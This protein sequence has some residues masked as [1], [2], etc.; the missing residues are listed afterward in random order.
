MWNQSPIVA[1]LVW[2]SAFILNDM[3]RQYVAKNTPTKEPTIYMSENPF[4]FSQRV[5]R[6]LTWNK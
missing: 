6:T 4:S 5:Y 3:G 1:G 2:E